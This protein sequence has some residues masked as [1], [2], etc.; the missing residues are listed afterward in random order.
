M[1]RRGAGRRP[2][3]EPKTLAS[4]TCKLIKNLTFRITTCIKLF[5]CFPISSVLCPCGGKGTC[6]KPTSPC[7]SEENMCSKETEFDS[8]RRAPRSNRMAYYA[9]SDTRIAYSDTNCSQPRRKRNDD[10]TSK[11]S[12]DCT[13][14][15]RKKRFDDCSDSGRRNRYDDD[16]EDDRRKDDCEEVEDECEPEPECPEENRGRGRGNPRYRPK[17]PPRRYEQNPERQRYSEPN[18]PDCGYQ[19]YNKKYRANKPPMGPTRSDHRVNARPYQMNA[20]T[21]AGV[22]MGPTCCK[23]VKRI[24]IR[25]EKR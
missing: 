7:P 2:C 12:D 23:G 25:C 17:T 5:L 1:Q 9:G 4:I 13:D 10:C 22:D 14:N 24:P 16:C 3:K 21:K 19:S 6:N 18:V 15:R 20:P 11:R 8:Q